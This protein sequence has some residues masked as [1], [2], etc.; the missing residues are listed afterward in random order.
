MRDLLLATFTFSALLSAAGC[1][2]SDDAGVEVTLSGDSKA[3]ALAGKRVEIKLPSYQLSFYDGATDASVTVRMRSDDK[4]SL[5]GEPIVYHAE[6]FGERCTTHSD[7][8][9]GS[10]CRA[11]ACVTTN[12]DHDDIVG[13]ELTSTRS[14][15]H[16]GFMLIDYFET[17]SADEPVFVS[18]GGVNVFNRVDIDYGTKELT[19]DGTKTYSFA[20]CG[21][22]PRQYDLTTFETFPV[23]LRTTDGSMFKGEYTYKPIVTVN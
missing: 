21:I 7:C 3:D 8:G 2:D 20:E 16:L 13:I 23:P 15:V 5:E 22:K 18:C 17:A 19:R 11:N 1:V 9:S 14:T 12:F 6:T 4:L 10:F